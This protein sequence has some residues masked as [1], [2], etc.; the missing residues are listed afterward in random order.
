MNE[1]RPGHSISIFAGVLSFIAGLFIG[2]VILGRWLWP[3]QWVG[4][5]LEHVDQ[6]IRTDYLHAA[7]DTYTYGQDAVLA[8]RRYNSL[9]KYKEAT[10]ADI[11]RTAN[12]QTQPAIAAFASAVK[13]SEVLGSKPPATSAPPGASRGVSGWAL[14]GLCGLALL[15]VAFSAAFVILRRR[16]RPA[17]AREFAHPEGTPSFPF[18]RTWKLRRPILGKNVSIGLGALI[19][20]LF[21]L[22][23]LAAPLLAPPDP[24]VEFSTYK[25]I[26][27]VNRN[28]PFQPKESLLLG[29]VPDPANL[30]QLDIWY[31]LVWGTRSALRFGILVVLFASAFGVIL[32]GVSAYLGGLTNTLIMGFTDAFLAVPVIAGVIFFQQF[33]LMLLRGSGVMV[34][35]NGELDFITPPT[36]WQR[37][38]TDLDPLLVAFI[39]FSWMP[40]ARLINSVV[41][42]A[43]Q[44]EYLLAARS[45]GAG[46]LRL[47][48]RHLIPNSISPAIVLAA[49]D[50]GYMVLLQAGFTFI[51]LS[52]RSEW[53]RLLSLGKNYVIGPGGNPFT[54]WW[55]FFPPTLAVVLFGVGWSLLGDGLNDWLNPHQS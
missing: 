45:L 30:R 6:A 34:F 37:F 28:I 31:S 51:G 48:F 5:T 4:G 33:V 22:T 17:V 36:A 47:V 18:A 25:D 8:S 3:V 29:S 14:G 39:V 2:L 55:I 13:A 50:V 35:W 1:R 21:V 53:G 7:I 38:L 27:Q 44:E 15:L 24:G 40:Y 52:Y 49:R 42:R 46:H 12:G 9:G 11:Y 16:S 54:Y 41:L 19:V 10:L 20:G 26:G 43:R 32:G 23:A